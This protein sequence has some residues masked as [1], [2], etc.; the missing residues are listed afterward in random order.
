MNWSTRPRTRRCRP[1]SRWRTTG[2]ASSLDQG[3]VRVPI[4]VDP[5]QRLRDYG[6]G[7][8]LAWWDELS[9]EQRRGLLD[10]LRALNQEQL[11]RLYADRDHAV[12]VPTADRIAPPPIIRQ[13]A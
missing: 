3:V 13:D 9:D 8:V 10:Q 6:Q 7:H 1:A 11:Q 5:R 4:P 12:A 2:C